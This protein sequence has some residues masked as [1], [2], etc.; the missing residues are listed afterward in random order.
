MTALGTP[1][2][3][4]AKKAPLVVRVDADVQDREQKD[5]SIVEQSDDDSPKYPAGQGSVP[6]SER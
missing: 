4:P 3:R 6:V 1:V 2:P 5:L